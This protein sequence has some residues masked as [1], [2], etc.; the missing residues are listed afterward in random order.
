MPAHVHVSKSSSGH[1]EMSILAVVSSE[2][3]I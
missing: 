3:R 1:K 2:G